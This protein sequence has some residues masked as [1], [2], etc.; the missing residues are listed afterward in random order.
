V[1]GVRRA[2]K[3]TRR[4]LFGLAAPAVAL[5]AQ[6]A[7]ALAG[8][9]AMLSPGWTF[10][11]QGGAAIYANVCAACHQSDASGAVGAGAYPP[12]KA[13]GELAS[14]DYVLRVLLNGQGAMPPVGAMMSDEQVADVV[15]YVR[16]HFG[17]AYAD[18]VSAA[19][20]KAAR[21]PER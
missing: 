20:V 6:S 19:A 3:G 14:A 12:L 16:S 7:A 15:N 11:E 10:A 4:L 13:N 5:L 18:A 1:T 9:G 17:N 8:E 21:P 2:A